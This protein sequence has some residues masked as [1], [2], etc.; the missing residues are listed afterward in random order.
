MDRL[1]GALIISLVLLTSALL[2]VILSSEEG[3]IF[4]VV[5]IGL[6]ALIGIILLTTGKEEIP[7]K[8][9]SDEDV[10]KELDDKP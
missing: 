5:C 8:L 6:S 10:E 7:G 2:S 9:L 3:F 4:S 1:F